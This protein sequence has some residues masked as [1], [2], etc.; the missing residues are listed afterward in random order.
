MIALRK[1][2]ATPGLA[3]VEA[4]EPG[5]L[6][7]NE[8]LIDVAAVGICGSD[9]HVDEWTAGYEF[10]EPL[11]PVTLGH[12]F[13][14]RVAAVGSHVT[15]V[16]IGERV[17]A[18][19]SAPCAT[20][21]P[22]KSGAPQNCTDKRTIGLQRDGAF[23]RR[24]VAR[25]S[26]VFQLSDKVDDD[27]AAL[28]EP[29]C[30]GARAVAVANVVQNQK[31]VVFGPGTIGQAIAMFARLSGAADVAIVGF[32]DAPRLAVA[33]ALGFSQTFD[34]AEADAHEHLRRSFAQAD[35]VFEATGHPSTPSDGLELL[36]NEG[37]LVLTG[38]HARPATVDLL[39]IVRRKLRIL[40]SH[41]SRREDWARVI[42]TL[43]RHGDAFRPMITHRLP[44]SRVEEGFSLAHSRAASKVIIHPQEGLAR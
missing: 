33:R 44:L 8:V 22:C 40:G 4:P 41:G 27:L 5:P 30:V 10:M 15:S 1:T 39:A 18:W 26:G 6:G 17:V 20:C 11:L 7:P 34:L 37:A 42:S 12:E 19:P 16:A 13:S 28:V 35:V 29:L 25:E 38:I 23:A 36:R 32:N 9:L 21:E 2:A 31:V 14:G 43:E 3:L 24:V